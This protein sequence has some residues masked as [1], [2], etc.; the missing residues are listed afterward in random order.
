[1]HSVFIK[2]ELS[3]GLF[4]VTAHFL[5]NLIYITLVSSKDVSLLLTYG[6]NGQPIKLDGLQVE[7]LCSNPC[8][9]IN[10]YV[11]EVVELKL[12]PQWTTNLDKNDI[13][14]KRRFVN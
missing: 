5:N 12:S 9:G 11:T 13:K 2:R 8:T 10:H 14:A 1:M 7:Y 4:Q 3:Y 6:L